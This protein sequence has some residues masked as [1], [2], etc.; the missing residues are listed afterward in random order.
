MSYMDIFKDIKA[1]K[2]SNVYLF[3]GE[4][5]YVKQEALD[6]LVDAIVEPTFKDMN[7][8][9]IDGSEVRADEIINACETLPFMADR[10]IVIV[11]DSMYLTRRRGGESYSAEEEKRMRDYIKDISP[12]SHLVFYV[13]GSVD[14]RG[15]LY[16]AIKKHGCAVEFN[17][18]KDYDIKRWVK[19]ELSKHGKTITSAALD[20]FVYLA[21]V[22]LDDVENELSKLVAFAYESDIITEEDVLSTITPTLEYSIFQLV[23]AIGNK[24]VDTALMLLDEMLDRGEVFYSILPMIGRQIRLILLCG[25]HNK[26]GYSRNQIAKTLKIHPYGVGKY[27]SQGRNFTEEELTS[28]LSDCLKLDHSIKQGKID[29]RLG[30]EMLIISMCT[31]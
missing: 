13:R 31:K 6:Q 29:G 11:R 8:Q 12:T 2:F 26:K 27:I 15:A 10:R 30:L 28:A 3:S 1:H 4:E 24:N 22:N 17:R 18:L 16:K 14:K 23:E 20:Q 25:A 19:K 5:E 9:T 21:G 7:Y